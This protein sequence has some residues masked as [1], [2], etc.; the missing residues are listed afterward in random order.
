MS[1]GE[2]AVR[3]RQDGELARAVVS[4]LETSAMLPEGKVWVAVR[5]GHVTLRG[6]VDSDC[7]RA[8]AVRLARELAGVRRVVDSITV[9]R[10]AEEVASALHSS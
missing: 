8:A 2:W 6:Q 10:R 7:Q 3:W 1:G 9:A 5:D 4:A